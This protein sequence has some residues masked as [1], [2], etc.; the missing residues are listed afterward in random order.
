MLMLPPRGPER[1][2]SRSVRWTAVSLSSARTSTRGVGILAAALLA[3]FLTG[4]LAGF[5]AG[6]GFL[7]AMSGEAER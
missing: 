6:M 7:M 3:G 2:E 5:L 1:I 4:F